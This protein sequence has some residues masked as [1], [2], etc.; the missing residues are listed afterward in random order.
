MISNA[1]QR[2]SRSDENTSE[3][4]ETCFDRRGVSY[5]LMKKVMKLLL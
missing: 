5:V 4:G 1:P 2:L 3:S